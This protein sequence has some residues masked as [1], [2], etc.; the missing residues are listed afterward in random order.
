MK[1]SR[2]KPFSEIRYFTDSPTMLGMLRADFTSLLE[3]MGTRV[4]EIK[5]K[6]HPVE[7]WY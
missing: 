2:G 7:E 4:S 6:S 5:T 1:T 3:F